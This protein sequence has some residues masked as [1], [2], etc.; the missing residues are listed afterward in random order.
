MTDAAPDSYV[1]FQVPEDWTEEYE[2]DGTLKF[3]ARGKSGALQVS[4]LHFDSG[5]SKLNPEQMCEAAFK[6]QKVNRMPQ[7]LRY[8]KSALKGGAGPTA[9]T[10]QRWEVAVPIQPDHMRIVIFEYTYFDRNA[11]EK[12]VTDELAMLDRNIVNAQYS[13]DWPTGPPA[14]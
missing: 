10:T 12:I 14:A 2:R 13:R 6:N 5:A 1:R 11:Q 3:P 7:G 8:T 4:Y 9:V